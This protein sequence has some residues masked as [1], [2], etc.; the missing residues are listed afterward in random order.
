[1]HTPTYSAPESFFGEERKCGYIISADMK[2][3]WAVELDLLAKF[4]E[5]CERNNLNYYIADG[6]LLG[7][8]R[9]GGFIPWDDDVDV[10]MPRTDYNRLWDI[11][12]QEFTHPYFFQ[13]T[14]SEGG[15]F[16]R[17]HAQIRNSDSTGFIGSDGRRKN[18]NCGIFLDIFVLDNI[19]NRLIERK[20]WEQEL[21]DAMNRMKMVFDPLRPPKNEREKRRREEAREFFETTN[22]QEYFTHM[23]REIMGRYEG[24]KTHLIGDFTLGVKGNTQ[25]P[26]AWFDGYCYLSFE[27]LRLRAPLFY[28]KVLTLEYGDYMKL[29]DDVSAMNGREHGDVTFDADTPYK[30]WFAAHREQYPWKTLE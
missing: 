25:W 13:T 18:V 28:T 11:A 3:N 20:L 27:G 30:E 26:A 9:H 22:L 21:L 4:A 12:E 17:E 16:Y 14:L 2:R 7:A 10:C 23:N 19:P 8:V 29:P 5:V 6:T 24:R 1:M 15:N